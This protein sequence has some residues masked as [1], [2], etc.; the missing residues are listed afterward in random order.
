MLK[1]IWKKITNML[2]C[3]ETRLIENEPPI[4]IQKKKI[5][6]RPEIHMISKEQFM[7]ELDEYVNHLHELKHKGRK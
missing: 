1:G 2:G 5:I 7:Q 3:D 6:N 4:I